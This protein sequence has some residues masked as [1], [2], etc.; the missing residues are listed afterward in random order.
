MRRAALI[1]LALLLCLPVE[2]K[3]EPSAEVD[4]A[5]RYGAAEWNISY[6]KLRAVAHCE[7][8][9][10][11]RATNGTHDGLLSHKRG[12]WDGRV[13]LFND[14]VRLHNSR[15]PDQQLPEMAGDRWA[16]IDQTRLSAAM[17]AGVLPGYKGW[18]P[19]KACA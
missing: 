12:S 19:W 11:P 17:V 6:T 8:T 16:A 3:P 5:L 18:G 4:A 15:H 14:H 10:N 9:W 7:S 1:P 13:R 2:A